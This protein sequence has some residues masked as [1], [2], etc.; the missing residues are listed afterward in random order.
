MFDARTFQFLRDLAKNNNRE[1]FK[2][3]QDRYET[4]VRAPAL[5]FI[6]AMAPKLRTISIHFDAVAK[7]SGGSLM[8]IH[9]DTRFG[10][11]KSPYKTNVGIQFRHERGRDVH[12]PGFYVHIEPGGCFLGAGIW[13]PDPAALRALRTEI[14]DHPRDWRRA[15]RAKRFMD[16]F[17]LAGESLK[18]PPQG[19]PTD[20]PY[21]DDLKRKDFIAVANLG[22]DAIQAAQLV[23][24]VTSMLRRT[25]AL[26]AFLCAAVDLDY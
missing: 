16:Q 13:R 20:H 6:E 4:F 22:E 5:S 26:M 14:V 21:L 7:R 10:R 11:D 8:R 9:R 15:T 3:N 25:N 17:A 24:T 1:W 23:T 12:A 2:R 18:R 19:F